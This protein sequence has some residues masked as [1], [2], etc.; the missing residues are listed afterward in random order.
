[1]TTRVAIA[2]FAGACGGRGRIDGQFAGWPLQP[3]L[4]R[5]LWHSCISTKRRPFSHC[6]TPARSPS[7]LRGGVGVGV[8]TR[9]WAL[10]HRSSVQP[11]QVRADSPTPN[12]LPARATAFTYL[13]ETA[14]SSRQSLHPHT[15]PSPRKGERAFCALSLASGCD[16]RLNLPRFGQMCE[17]RSPTEEETAAAVAADKRRLGVAASRRPEPG[18]SAIRSRA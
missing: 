12:P 3:L 10:V 5:R 1:M 8:R 2:K 17:S 11:L 9:R 4:L 16:L 6:G 7:P 15:Q 14:M 18:A 13:T